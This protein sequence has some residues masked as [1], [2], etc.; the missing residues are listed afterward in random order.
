MPLNRMIR[1]K[2]TGLVVALMCLLSTGVLAQDQRKLD[3][4]T[5]L[6]NSLAPDTNRVK[7][8]I[9]LS[10]I[11]APSNFEESLKR[12]NEAQVLSSQI[13]SDHWEAYSY[14]AIGLAHGYNQD[15]QN[16]RLNYLRAAA[17]FDK[18]DQPVQVANMYL[19]SGAEFY[20]GLQ[21]DSSLYYYLIAL[22]MYE[23]TQDE[24]GM[25]KAYNNLA[26]VYRKMS[27]SEEAI[28]MYS[29]S[30]KQKEAIGDEQGIMNTE[31]NLGALY[32]NLDLYDESLVHLDK[33]YNLAISLDNIEIQSFALMNIAVNHMDRR[34]L[35]VALSKA[36]QS[37]VLLIQQGIS[38]RL[39]TLYS[40]MGAAHSLRND[41]DSAFYYVARSRELGEGYLQI[42]EKRQNYRTLAD[43]EAQAGN[44]QAAYEYKALELAYGDTIA[45]DKQQERIAAIQVR[46]EQE[47]RQSTL[48]EQEKEIAEGEAEKSQLISVITI[49]SSITVFLLFL[50]ILIQLRNRRR[51]ERDQREVEKQLDEIELLRSKVAAIA[52]VPQPG[53]AMQLTGQEVNA[54]LLS[55]LTER[56]LE[57]LKL[58]AA[59][60]S[61]QQIADETFV[62]INT[63]KTHVN[64]IYDKLDVKNRTQ[65]TVKASKLQLL[66]GDSDS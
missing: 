56:E 57:V 7:T 25:A 51:R 20:Y 54:L 31:L 60:K 19:N 59:G 50:I 65:A 33:A 13:N 17:I 34:E 27:M 16:A 14:K 4:L 36:R 18:L 41:C 24:A 2:L 30:L 42:R 10:K 6:L 15:P 64:H 12:A 39:G 62:S 47:V 63:I 29:K 46:Y 32:Y 58:I 11:Y 5:N 38:R 28:E 49:V 40:M 3:S 21:Y 8:L 53:M 37:E 22:P 48:L 52:E 55:P 26:L 23:Q 43:C 45:A 1:S 66:Q 61:N 35:D 9:E 44:Y